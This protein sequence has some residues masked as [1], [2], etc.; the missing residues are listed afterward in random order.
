MPVCHALGSARR[1]AQSGLRAFETRKLDCQVMASSRSCDRLLGLSILLPTYSHALLRHHLDSTFFC[2]IPS[3]LDLPLLNNHKQ[4]YAYNIFQQAPNSFRTHEHS[5]SRQRGLPQTAS[6][7]TYTQ[8][9]ERPNDQFNSSPTM[10]PT[11]SSF[12]QKQTAAAHNQPS[13]PQ[14]APVQHVLEITRDHSR[15]SSSSLASPETSYS[16]DSH[17]SSIDFARCS[18][19]QRTPSFDSKTGENNMVQYGLN[20]WYC[21]RCASMVGLTNR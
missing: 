18:R 1:L 14:P 8:H 15:R 11:T 9:T 3:T 16:G 5:S 2:F 10:S 4:L 7:R 13:R 19:C 12:L 6:G 21:K 20:L 17:K